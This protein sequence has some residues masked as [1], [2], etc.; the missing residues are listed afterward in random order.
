[1]NA[2][3]DISLVLNEK[4]AGEAGEEDAGYAPCATAMGAIILALGA[5]AF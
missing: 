2:S 3:T 1:M 4:A 5:L